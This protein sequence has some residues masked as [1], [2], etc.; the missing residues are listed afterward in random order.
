VTS[1]GGT[2]VPVAVDH[3][4]P[5]QAAVL[6]EWIRDEFGPIDVLVNDV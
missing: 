6:A 2:G 5:G 1:L 3:V 4:E